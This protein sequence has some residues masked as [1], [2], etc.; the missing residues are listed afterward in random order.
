MHVNLILLL[1]GDLF[2]L[3]GE[4]SFCFRYEMLVM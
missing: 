3:H 1:V 4:D 2:F